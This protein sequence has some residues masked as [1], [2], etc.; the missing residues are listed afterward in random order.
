MK[1]YILICYTSSYKTASITAP[2]IGINAANSAATLDPALSLTVLLF[3]ALVN[4]KMY[5][6]F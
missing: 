4:Y 6:K 5:Y 1:Q 3:F 2:S